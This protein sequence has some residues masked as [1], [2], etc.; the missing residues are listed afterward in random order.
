MKKHQALSAGIQNRWP[1]YPI[2]GLMCTYRNVFAP[3]KGAA[4]RMF[5]ATPWPPSQT[6]L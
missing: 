3:S 4:C 1:P 2:H 6:G 5:L